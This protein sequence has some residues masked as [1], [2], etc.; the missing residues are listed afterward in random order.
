MSDLTLTP[1]FGTYQDL[2]YDAFLIQRCLNGEES[3]FLKVYNQYAGSI[4]RLCYG[5]LQHRED[6]EETLQDS[7]EYAFRRLE[8]Y[9]GS[10]ASFKTCLYQIANSRCRNKRRRKILETISLSQ[11]LDEQVADLSLL[12]PADEI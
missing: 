10:R 11:V 7:F 4:Y 1:G 6:S 2:H 8:K 3:A 9:D 5:M 12:T